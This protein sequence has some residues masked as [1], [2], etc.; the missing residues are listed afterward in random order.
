LQRIGAPAAVG[1]V[2]LLLAV[3]VWRSFSGGPGQGQGGDARGIVDRPAE[4]RVLA[5]PWAEI[6]IDG[7]L[8]DVTPV[9]R[10]IQ[11]SPG[12]HV[13]LFKH[14]NAPDERRSVEI[15]AG[16]TIVLDVQM[17]V[18]RPVVDAGAADA[19]GEDDSP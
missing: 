3:I 17:Q 16:Q 14:P 11:V 5:E 15:I 8:V 1:L 13:V 7:K 4:L 19:G 6:H 18:V 10:P 12:R 2:A 9:G